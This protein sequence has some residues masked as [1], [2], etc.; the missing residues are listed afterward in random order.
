MEYLKNIRFR[1]KLIIIKYVN[2]NL[3]IIIRHSRSYKQGLHEKNSVVP[4]HR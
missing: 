4:G 1:T 3:I 2:M